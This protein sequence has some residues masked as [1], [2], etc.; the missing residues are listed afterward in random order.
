MTL[1][2]RFDVI[3]TLSPHRVSHVGRRLWRSWSVVSS[4]TFYRD[5]DN[6]DPR[7]DVGFIVVICIHVGS[8]AYQHPESYG[9]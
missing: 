1:R 3:L 5:P 4:K 6:K 2:R 7:I 8:T 9:L